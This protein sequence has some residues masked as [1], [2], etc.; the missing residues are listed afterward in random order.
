MRKIFVWGWGGGLG[1]VICGWGDLGLGRRRRNGGGECRQGGHIFIFSDGLTDGKTPS[2]NPSVIV[3][4]NRHVTAQTCFSN[5]SVILSVFFTVHRSGHLVR[6][7][8]SYLSVFLTV[9][10]SR[11]P[12]G[13][14]VL[15][16]SVILLEKSPAKT[17]AS[18]TRPFFINSELCVRNLVGNYRRNIT[19]GNYRSNYGCKY[20]VGN[21]DRKIPTEIYRRDSVG[22]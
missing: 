5:P 22:I 19:V 13:S 1:L 16:P 9:N 11:H 18:G 3:T 8:H 6:I 12:Y 2:V 4:G 20:S 10:R 14:Q 15:N 21:F 17:F 7:W